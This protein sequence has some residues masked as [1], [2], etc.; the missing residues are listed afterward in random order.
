MGMKFEEVLPYLRVGQK[1]RLPSYDRDGEYWIAGYAGIIGLT[2]KSL[3]IHRFNKDGKVF[4][5]E[6]DWGI[7]KWVIMSDEWEIVE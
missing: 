1:V 4:H 2:E 7:P 6:K 3:T 5:G